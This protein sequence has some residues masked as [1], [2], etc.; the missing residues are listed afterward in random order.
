MSTL[1]AQT[2]SNGSVSTSSA[3]VIRGSARAWVNYNISSG[4]S[5][6]IRDSYN[7]SSVTYVSA[8]KST[9]NYTNA[10]ANINYCVQATAS[11][12][13]S[14]NNSTFAYVI[15]ADAPTTTS[16]TIGCTNDGGA[17]RNSIYVYV[18]VFS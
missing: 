14:N 18:T 2:I 17:T 13:N 15:E 4:S 16:T 10:F 11:G 12:I 8:G 9:V 3:N 7:V 1:V 5:A 6:P